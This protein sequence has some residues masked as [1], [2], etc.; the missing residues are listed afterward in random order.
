MI[1][2]LV[3]LLSRENP[4]ELNR[5][6]ADF[7]AAQADLIPGGT[8][9]DP[10]VEARLAV[11]LASL[12]EFRPAGEK[13]LKLLRNRI[14]FSQR[15]DTIS[16][17]IAAIGGSAVVASDSSYEKT[18]AGLLA[19]LGSLCS[20]GVK[21]LRQGFNGVDA[22]LVKDYSDIKDLVWQARE[23]ELLLQQMENQPENP[24]L[25]QIVN[26]SNQLAARL[27]TILLDYV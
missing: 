12:K 15:L 2:E 23:K 20:L 21:T 5:L 17:I 24:E 7:P 18:C 22:G 3:N 13:V 9:G 14:R 10:V 19:L 25:P 27:N 4:V 26:A 1:N 8:L 16:Q 11:T 6:R